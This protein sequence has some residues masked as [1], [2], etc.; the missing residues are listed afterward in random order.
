MFVEKEQ[1]P[2]SLNRSY[3]M[4]TTLIAI[5][6]SALFLQGLA[7]PAPENS[8]GDDV[9][10]CVFSLCTDLQTLLLASCYLWPSDCRAP[11]RLQRPRHGPLLL[12]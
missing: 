7:L 2:T 9:L 5:V 6:A 12:H 10:S 1:V 11:P 3:S 4:K 8:V